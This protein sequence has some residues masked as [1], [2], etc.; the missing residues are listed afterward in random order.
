MEKRGIVPSCFVLVFVIIFSIILISSGIVIA[1]NETNS[2]GNTGESVS[3]NNDNSNLDGIEKGYACLRDEIEDKQG[4]SLEESIFSVLAL[5]A[6]SKAIE[7]IE[8]EE[9]NG[10]CWPK[11]DCNTKRTAQAGL[12]YDRISRNTGEIKSWLENRK[13]VADDLTWFLEID[14]QNHVESD[15]SIK[16][17]GDTRT[18]QIN[19]DLT[20][21]G[22]PGSCL[23]ISNS[24]YWLR[25]RDDC[26][27]EEFEVSCDQDFITTL[28]Y[29]K[30]SGGTLYV[31]SDTHSSGGLGTTTEKIESSCL[32]SEA[33]DSDCDYE[34]TLWGALALDKMGEEIDEFLPYL[35]ALS[36][37]NKEFFPSAFLHIL[38]GDEDQFTQVTQS[39]KQNK[40]WEIVG[41]SENRFY[42]TSLGMLSLSGSGATELGNAKTY[43]LDIQQESGCW[44][45]NNIKST[46]FVL[47]SGWSRAV[48]GSGG[49]SGTS[50]ACEPSN[51]YCEAR[52]ACLEGAGTIQN[53]FDCSNFAEVCCS[54]DIKE[55]TCS[56]KG[57][58]LC[59]SN[60]ECSGS[61]SSA[62]DGT[63]CL[64]ACINK[65][66]ESTCEITGGSCR[67]NC[68]DNEEQNTESCSF[69]GDVCCVYSGNQN[70]G[71]S[72]WVWIILIILIILV[73]LGIWKRNKIRLWMHK[74]KGNASSKPMS[75]NTGRRGPP[76]APM[77]Q[78]SPRRFNPFGIQG[79]PM[80]R[81][82]QG[83]RS[84]GKKTDSDFEETM[85]KLREM[86]G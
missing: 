57:G 62:V 25:V 27:E 30:S 8:D 50:T 75:G 54:V 24:G 12:A 37:D 59:G 7:V 33:G 22:N 74:M 45:N 67:N 13:Q 5:G 19:E 84:S 72:V 9:G 16:T 6:N 55:Q 47:Y 68:L 85:R 80:Q 18:I 17:D 26:L 78:N 20:L 39:Q 4:L 10:G 66:A 81:P 28:L 60:Q 70:E 56:E 63:C 69:S 58:I 49:G 51:G 15:C 79:R 29:Q 40:F 34:G 2:S 65:P 1:A 42:D 73:A 52:F 61:T 83:T 41:S 35:L 36:E 14:I 64:D 11:S 82:T 32:N 23:V 21:Q 38:T 48:S 46:G 53:N 31:S 71:I 76:G 43:L 44:D 86:G 77:R 3:V